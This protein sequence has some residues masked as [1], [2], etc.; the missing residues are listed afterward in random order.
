MVNMS[1][2]TKI[3]PLIFSIVIVLAYVDNFSL[4]PVL[5]PYAIELG[6]SGLILGV[7]VASYS[8]S[9]DIFEV[10]IGYIADRTKRRKLIL[11]IGMLLNSIAIY[12]YS[13]VN[14]PFQLIMARFIHGGFG[15]LIGPSSMALAKTTPNP[16]SSL[17]GRMGA[18]GVAIMSGAIV[19]WYMGGIIPSIYGI[20]GFFVILAVVVFL[21]MVL[22]IFIKESE[23]KINV[24]VKYSARDFFGRTIGILRDRYVL[25]GLM[26]LFGVTFT[27][28]S[29]TTLLPIIASSYIDRPP[30]AVGIFLGTTAVLAF[31]LQIPFGIISDRVGRI[32]MLILSILLI[33]TGIIMA[34]FSES[35]KG[36]LIASIPYG[37]G[38]S[39]LFPASA[40]LVLSRVD[41]EDTSLASSLFHIMITEGVVWGAILTSPLYLLI[42][43]EYAILTSL[44][45]CIFA[46]ILLAFHSG[47]S[48]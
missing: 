2:K 22:S 14:T 37:A 32:K 43:P 3:L 18:Y 38:Y 27:Q 29:V 25:N 28:G 1:V 15:S 41:D 33:I 10:A 12:A 35:I 48:I 9:E 26:A 47:K 30:L 40:A 6:A 24:E 19:G 46:L 36:L 31:I 42:T 17:G 45:P 16:L 7:I 11:T 39:I 5:T 20:R 13:L 44:V 8:L 21:G 23:E 34:V 4:H